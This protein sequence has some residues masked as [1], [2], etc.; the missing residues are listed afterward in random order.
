MLGTDQ[1]GVLLSNDGGKTWRASNRGFA[2]RRI[3]RIMPL[4]SEGKQSLTGLLS[5]GNRGGFYLFDPSRPEWSPLP[6]A[7]GSKLEVLCMLDLPDER[8]T[9][10]GTPQGIH[11]K[12]PLRPSP[13]NARTHRPAL[14]QR[15]GARQGTRVGLAGTNEGIYRARPTGTE[16]FGARRIY[17]LCASVGF[18]RLG[19]ESEGGLRGNPHGTAA[20]PGRRR[21]LGHH[22]HWASAR[23]PGGVPGGQSLAEPSPSLPDRCRLYEIQGRRQRL[24][25]VMFDGSGAHVLR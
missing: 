2:A 4:V 12:S 20:F 13:S 17:G 16:F 15:P 10:Y 24:A 18:G 3:S 21:D 6:T 11:W 14:G 5:E 25:E 9:L 23:H 7:A 22:I 8:G 19:L 1:A